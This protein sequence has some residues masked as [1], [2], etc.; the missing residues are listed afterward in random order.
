MT[1]PCTW[2]GSPKHW[3]NDCDE[4]KDALKEFKAGKKKAG[5]VHAQ[6]EQVDDDDED[7]EDAAELADLD[8]HANV[9]IGHTIEAVLPLEAFNLA[10]ISQRKHKVLIDNQA[11]THCFSE[12]ALLSN[13]RDGPARMCT[14]TNGG[15]H[16]DLHVDLH[17]M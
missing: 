14:R 16:L 10:N 6:E 5:Q 2:C 8:G 13:I 11:T 15:K 4:Y 3:Q 1:C 17:D 7:G 9:Q 12:R